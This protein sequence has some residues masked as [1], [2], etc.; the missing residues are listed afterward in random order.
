M[1]NT[2]MAHWSR[3][4]GG[5]PAFR[6]FGKG[7]GEVEW[8]IIDVFA[9]QRRNVSSRW[10]FWGGA[11]TTWRSSVIAVGWDFAELVFSEQVVAPASRDR[12]IEVAGGR[13]RDTARRKSAGAPSFPSASEILAHE[14]GHTWQALRLGAAYLP[15]VGSM[16]LFREGS[17]FWNHY[18]NQASEMGLFGGMLNGSVCS[19]LVDS[20]RE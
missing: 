8:R 9:S 14:C 18:E 17:R 19:R 15:L 1:F 13:L 3:W 4:I 10:P 2:G 12:Y 6:I 20:R 7:R 11:C 16:T 5:M